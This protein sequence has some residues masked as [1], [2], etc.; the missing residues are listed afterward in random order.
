MMSPEPGGE[1]QKGLKEKQGCTQ[2]K[3]VPEFG[4]DRTGQIAEGLRHY[5]CAMLS[6]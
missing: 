3:R 1:V 4:R 6:Q 5:L 2:Y